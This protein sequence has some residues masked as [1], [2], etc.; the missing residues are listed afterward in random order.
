[1]TLAWGRDRK[2]RM[3]IMIVSTVRKITGWAASASVHCGTAITA[4]TQ[5][6]QK[7][8]QAV[9]SSRLGSFHA[10]KN[11]GMDPR[12]TAERLVTMP[13]IG[14][15]NIHQRTMPTTAPPRQN[16][17]SR[18]HPGVPYLNAITTTIHTPS[19]APRIWP[20]TASFAY[21]P[22]R[23]IVSSVAQMI[24]VAFEGFVSPRTMARM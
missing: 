20:L 22:A 1:M 2:Y 6:N 19:T 16:L 10:D 21:M 14:L 4:A 9:R 13:R 18:V 24:Q 12:N 3:Y 8:V 17:S 5:D 7:I 15:L 23:V 11:V